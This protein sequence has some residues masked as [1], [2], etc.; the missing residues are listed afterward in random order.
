[1]AFDD[2]D[3]CLY[4]ENRSGKALSCHLTESSKESAYKLNI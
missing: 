2:D 4:M 3:G 1:M